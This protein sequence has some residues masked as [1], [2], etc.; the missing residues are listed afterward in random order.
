MKV[1][2]GWTW[3]C[4]LLLFG[5]SHPMLTVERPIADG[6]LKVVELSNDGQVQETGQNQV[7][8]PH[9]V[10]GKSDIVVRGKYIYVG[11][12]RHLYF[13]EQD[14]SGNLH[15]V[16]SLPIKGYDIALALHPED[17]I[18]YVA[19]GVEVWVVD[20]ENLEKPRI[21][22]NLSLAEELGKSQP[23]QH[24]EQLTATD[25]AC[26][27]GKLV[28]TI[29]GSGQ[30]QTSSRQGTTLVFDVTNPFNPQSERA[31]DKLSGASAIAMGLFN[32]QMFVAGDRVIEYQNFKQEKIGGDGWLRKPGLKKYAEHVRMPGP[33][34]D[35]RFIMGSRA[36]LDDFEKLQRFK[37]RY[38][39]ADMSE[40]QQLQD[41]MPL[42]DGVLYIATEHAITY[43]DTAFKVVLWGP[44]NK[45]EYVS[46]YFNLIS[47][48]D[49][50]DYSHV[51]LA[52][53][54]DGISILKR[55]PNRYRL[56]TLTRYEDLPSPALDVCVTNGKLYILCGELNLKNVQ[57]NESVRPK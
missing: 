10:T 56:Q 3:L 33:V 16:S 48:M 27:D 12:Y 26:E 32:H 54:N 8:L 24:P 11:S 1:A 40:R 4:C 50:R 47:G 21:V 46:D 15:I 55:R 28:V 25:V 20:A 7:K 9:P 14:L 51:Y 19:A 31:L 57:Y 5:C 43:M 13:I 36:E 30:S 29:Q 37:N 23:I 35:L 34:V 42:D 44:N 18:I 39:Q 45:N 2:A 53:G 38:R 49:A 6:Y 41:L 22:R 17:N 52:T